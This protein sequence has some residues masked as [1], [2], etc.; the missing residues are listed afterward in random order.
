MMFAYVKNNIT[1]HM[2]PKS[3]SM[4]M[5]VTRRYIISIT[6]LNK[7]TYRNIIRNGMHFSVV[8]RVGLPY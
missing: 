8:H 5:P 4:C 3:Y 2:A 6:N 1:K 7:K